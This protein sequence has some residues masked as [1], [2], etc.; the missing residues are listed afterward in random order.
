MK[1][2]YQ[3]N[4]I[5]PYCDWEDQDSWEFDEEEG[6]YQCGS[7]E[8]EFNVVRDVE[9]TYS[10]SM[11]NC[12]DNGS[13]HDY[14]IDRYHESSRTFDY[15]AWCDKPKSE[16]E[17]YRIEICAKCGHKNFIKITKKEFDKCSD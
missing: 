8:K 12:D 11:L 13:K 9:I 3:N 10:T 7:C 6:I 2:E 4:I 15:G 5:C 16:W 14:N 17:Y 1:H